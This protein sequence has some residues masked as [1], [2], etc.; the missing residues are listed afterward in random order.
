MQNIDE[1]FRHMYITDRNRQIMQ[2][3]YNSDDFKWKLLRNLNIACILWF[4]MT[5]VMGIISPSHDTNQVLTYFI[6]DSLLALANIYMTI[7]IYDNIER[8]QKYF[9]KLNIFFINAGFY[10]N[11]ASAIWYICLYFYMRQHNLDQND[12]DKNVASEGSFI[13]KSI[14]QFHEIMRFKIS[15]TFHAISYKLYSDYLQN[16]INQLVKENHDFHSQ[17]NTNINS[18][19]NK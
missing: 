14:R 3:H 12:A 6:P 1:D 4:F 13:E 19:L 16:T 2:N 7:V 11:I 9:T 18:N 8:L 17:R 10:I 15:A 5:L